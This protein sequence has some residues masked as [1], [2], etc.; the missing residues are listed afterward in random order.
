MRRILQRKKVQR[1]WTKRIIYKKKQQSS[2][3]G[4]EI[5]SDIKQSQIQF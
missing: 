4:H 3:S 5:T 2:H 1:K